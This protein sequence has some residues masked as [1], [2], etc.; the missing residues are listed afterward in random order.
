MIVSYAMR[1]Q[2]TVMILDKDKQEDACF[3]TYDYTCYYMYTNKYE[4]TYDDMYYNKYKVTYDC[5]G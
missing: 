2:T 4:Y 1:L 5:A 3:Y